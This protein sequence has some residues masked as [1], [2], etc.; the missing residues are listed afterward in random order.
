[1]QNGGLTSDRC[2][3]EL[4]KTLGE[5]L[6]QWNAQTVRVFLLE[7]ASQCGAASTQKQA[8]L[9]YLSFRGEARDDLDIAIPAVAHW[10]LAALPLD[11]RTA[12]SH[13]CL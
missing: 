9:R 11:G 2:A 4:R 6:S 10:R 3:A 8:F 5:D 7:R 13:R 1:M 12:A